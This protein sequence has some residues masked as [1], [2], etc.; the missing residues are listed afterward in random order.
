MQEIEKN[1]EGG[2]LFTQVG[3]LL[4]RIIDLTYT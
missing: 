1:V 4:E 3:I 2:S